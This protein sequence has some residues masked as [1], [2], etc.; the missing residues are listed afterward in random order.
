[1]GQLPEEEALYLAVVFEETGAYQYKKNKEAERGSGDTGDGPGLRP[2]FEE[3][4][5]FG[6]EDDN[7]YWQGTDCDDCADPRDMRT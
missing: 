5:S 6:E 7:D 1:M 3:T 4:F 2:G